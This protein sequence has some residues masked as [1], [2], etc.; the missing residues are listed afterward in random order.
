MTQAGKED[1]MLQGQMTKN[2]R[3][4]GKFSIILREDDSN[5]CSYKINRHLFDTLKKYLAP[6]RS[7][8]SKP[9]KIRCIETGQIFY[10]AREAS[11]WV[12][13]NRKIAYSREASY[14]V[15]ANRK[16]AYCDMNL[17]KQ[18]CKGKQKTSYG[19]HWVFVEDSN[20]VL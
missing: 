13:A 7:Y 20:N 15:E 4:K 2:V 5:Q 1:F 14:W 9:R 12:E 3:K 18:T 19:Y 17:I 11:Y 8:Q 6:F 10:S 16:I